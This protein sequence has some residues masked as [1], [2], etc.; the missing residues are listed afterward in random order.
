[1]EESPPQVPVESTHPP[2]GKGRESKASISRGILFRNPTKTPTGRERPLV[3]FQSSSSSAES[4]AGE[5][6]AIYNSENVSYKRKNPDS[7]QRKKKK[8]GENFY[9]RVQGQS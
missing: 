6:I 5:Q 7:S 2:G 8:K 9:P 4:A 3:Q 1:M